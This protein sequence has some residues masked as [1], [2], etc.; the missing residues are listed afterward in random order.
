MP[1]RITNRKIDT[2]E[3]QG[4]GSFIVIKSLPYGVTRQLNRIST[5]MQDTENMEKETPERRLQI[6]EDGVAFTD[7]I[8]ID[9]LVEWNWVDDL[10][11]PMSL[12]SKPEDLDTL[13]FEEIQFIIECVKG[14]KVNKDEAKN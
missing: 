9:S 13:T 12:P 4:E 6:V 14:V 5:L 1:Q 11:N 3:L 2:P 10:G 7:K 8:V